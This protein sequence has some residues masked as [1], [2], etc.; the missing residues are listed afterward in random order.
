MARFYLTANAAPWASDGVVVDKNGSRHSGPNV[1]GAWTDAQIEAAFPVKAPTW[2]Q[3]PAG[4]M[5][6]TETVAVD[7]AGGLTFA[8]TFKIQ[9]DP[10][11]AQIFSE[12]TLRVKAEAK[13]RLYAMLS[14]LTLFQY[15]Q[16]QLETRIGNLTAANKTQ[17]AGLFPPLAGTDLP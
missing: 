16:A 9:P 8:R 13:Q 11:P 17:V 15:T 4:Q 10:T 2:G 6:D 1:L 7:G 3:P 14:E 5:I 12:M